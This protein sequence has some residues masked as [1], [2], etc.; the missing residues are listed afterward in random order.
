MGGKVGLKGTDGAETL[1]RALDLGASPESAR[2]AAEALQPLASFAH[3]VTFV[4]GPG[5]MGEEVV[6]EWGGT[7]EVLELAVEGPTTPQH[8]RELAT[9]MGDRGVD[10]LLFAGG[11]GTAR[12]IVA[13]LQDQV[14]CLGIPTGVKMHSAAF[15]VSPVRGGELAAHHLFGG[16]S[17]RTG[18]RT[19]TV[20]AEIMDIDEEALRE[21]RLSAR[22]FG[23]MTIP[24]RQGHTQGL[25]AGSPADERG[26]QQA[27]AAAIV[28]SMQEGVAY[29]VGPGTTT[30]EVMKL[31][32][33]E[34]TL[35]GVDMVRNRELLGRD[36]TE[37]QILA[38]LGEG[39]GSIIV[40]PVGGQGFL[41]GR[42][43]QPISPDVI[44]RVGRDR[45]IIGTTPTKL[46]SLG[47]EPLKV[48]T[49][50]AETD[51]WL[52][53]HQRM[54]TGYRERSVYRIA[55]A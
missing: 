31:L 41:F 45:I 10:L 43:N 21:G 13:Q 35:V 26:V 7:P 27:I 22:L 28:D 6:K 34:F 47:G 44:R 29:V 24:F 30:A 36:L 17:T 55:G 20:P 18:A 49:G 51:Q 5:E 19:G 46:A 50:D 52:T 14:V 42:G 23:F 9:L 37:S 39:P 1:Q 32:G 8:T 54:V 25:K 48:D 40:T 38:L 12:D 53:G 15:A 2:R 33:L 11:D 16:A 3:R 4:T